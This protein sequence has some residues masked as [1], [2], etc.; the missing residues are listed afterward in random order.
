MTKL[1]FVLV[2]IS[3]L[4]IS[5]IQEG[6]VV[7]KYY[8][9]SYIVNDVQYINKTPIFIPRVVPESYNIIIEKEGKTNYFKIDKYTY[10]KIKI[11][12]YYDRRFQ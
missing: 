12:D 2:L 5:C 3:F 10:D 7:E 1:L 6:V 9:S 4:F 11:G 8:K